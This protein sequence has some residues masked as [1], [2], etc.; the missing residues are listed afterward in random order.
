MKY[1][2]PHL[3]INTCVV[4]EELIKISGGKISK[5]G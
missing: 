4:L 1:N 3:T 5:D 2:F